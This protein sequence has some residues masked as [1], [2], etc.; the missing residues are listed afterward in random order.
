MRVAFT[1]PGPPEGKRRPRF[2]ARHGIAR[3]HS[4]PADIKR[5]SYIRQLARA[6]MGDEEPFPWAVRITITAVFE[7]TPSWPKRRK[8]EALQ[9]RFHTTKPDADNIEKS[10]LDGCLPDPKARAEADRVPFCLVDDCYVAELACR[11]RYGEPARTEVVIE[12][13]DRGDLI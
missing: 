7:V 5:E 3:M 6:A 10:V 1:I 8:A 4:D 9:M 2:S 11:K 13:L 12:A